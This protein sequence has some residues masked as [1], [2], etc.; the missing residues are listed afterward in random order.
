VGRRSC[1]DTIEGGP[2]DDWIVEGLG[3]QD[4]R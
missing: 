1:G 2:G 3:R 4:G